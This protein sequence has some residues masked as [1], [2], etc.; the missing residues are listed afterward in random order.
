MSKT[1]VNS[2]DERNKKKWGCK[3]ILLFH[4]L[5]ASTQRV[6]GAADCLAAEYITTEETQ[7]RLDEIFTSSRAVAS[8]HLVE[9]GIV[10][11]WK[12]YELE[13]GRMA[14]ADS[15]QRRLVH[16]FLNSLPSPV[17]DPATNHRI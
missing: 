16:G 5:V 4:M 8:H 3:A 13:D 10:V 11:L 17:F 12:P 9:Q 1:N 2:E 6:L 15:L 14:W 7:R